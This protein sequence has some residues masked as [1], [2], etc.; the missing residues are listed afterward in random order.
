MQETQSLSYMKEHMSVYEHKGYVRGQMADTNVDKDEEEDE[1]E[2]QSPFAAVVQSA[3]AGTVK[4]RD[5]GTPIVTT[6]SPFTALPDS[7]KWTTMTTDHIFFE[8]LPD[9]TGK[10]QQFKEVLKKCRKRLR[11][12]DLEPEGDDD[13]DK[14]SSKSDIKAIDEAPPSASDV[15]DIA[16]N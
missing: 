6:H 14:E 7:S 13:D 12:P 4:S 10:Y 9:S 8:N 11:Q 3:S 2:G 1:V 16:D 5:E 15:I